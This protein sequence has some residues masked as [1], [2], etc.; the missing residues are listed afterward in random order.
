MEI[1][2]TG[3]ELFAGC[4][5]SMLGAELAGLNTEL[6]IDI[7][8]DAIETLNLNLGC[9]PYVRILNAD[10]RDFNFSSLVSP[11]VICG[12]P[13]CQPFSSGGKLQGSM[14]IR[15]MFPE[16]IHSIRTLQPR[17]FI[18]ENVKGL[19]QERFTNFLEYIILQLSYPEL[20]K[21]VNESELD[22]H[23]RL[24]D[25][26]TN[27]IADDLSYNVIIRV[28][29]AADYGVPQKRERV[30][31][32][33]FRSDEHHRWHFPEKTHSYWELLNQQDNKGEYW[34]KYGIAP[35]FNL[36]SKQ[37]EEILKKKEAGPALKPWQTT[38]DAIYDLI[39]PRV[40]QGKNFVL[41]HE[42]KSGAKEY[43][44]HTGSTLDAPAKAIKAGANGNPG[45]ENMFRD[46]KGTLRY[47]TIREMARIQSF[48]DSYRFAGSWG[49]R[50]KQIGNAVPSKLSEI[51][52]S[53]IVQT[54]R[55]Q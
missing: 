55:S 1:D 7:D 25:Y 37:R 47:F 15:N 45:G 46:D 53:G 36:S 52:I 50:I 32:V 16:A 43:K 6:A 35:R 18:F 27:G 8:T 30:F 11:D 28:L 54:L 39:D 10:I 44:G 2:V 26:K 40:N 24:E 34:E 14:D 4:G 20:S 51:L 33:G 31:I 21:A 48:P 49:S 5:G 22:H 9:F 13:P 42:F 41:D 29:N 17:S 38:R 23:R 12:S 19:T 3:L